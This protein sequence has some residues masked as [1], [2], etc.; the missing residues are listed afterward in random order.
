[1]FNKCLLGNRAE[2]IYFHPYEHASIDTV[3]QIK[4]LVDINIKQCEQRRC[5]CKELDIG[6]SSATDLPMQVASKENTWKCIKISTNKSELTY[7]KPK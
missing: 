1:M 2:L 4:S 3:L 7:Q 6:G 5:P